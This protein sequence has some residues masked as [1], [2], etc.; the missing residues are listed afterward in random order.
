MVFEKLS[1]HC[2]SA[3]GTIRACEKM[4]LLAWQH[5]DLQN[6]VSL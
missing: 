4:R 6:R 1:M 5:V 2:S 3:Q